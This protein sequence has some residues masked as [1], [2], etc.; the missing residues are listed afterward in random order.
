MQG[1]GFEFSLPPGITLVPLCCP[2]QKIV[3]HPSVDGRS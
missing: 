1:L 3:V 2:I